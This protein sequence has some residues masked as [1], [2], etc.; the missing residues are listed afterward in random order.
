LPRRATAPP[1][2][3]PG[4]L[5]LWYEEPARSWPEALPIGNGRLGAMVFGGVT[6]ERLQLNEDTLYSDEPGQR[7]LPLEIT[8]HFDEVVRLL[9]RRYYREAEDLINRHWLGRVWPCYQPLADLEVDFGPPDRAQAYRRQLDL[10]TAICRV[11]YQ[12]RG[13]AFEREVF[14]SHPDQVIVM[15]VRAH[16]AQRLAFRASLT[17]V[18]PTARAAADGATGLILKGQAP[19][20]VIR[21]TLEWIEQMGDTWKYPELWDENG[22]R[23]PFARQVLYGAEIEGRG[24]FFEVRLRVLAQG[25]ETRAAA[26]GIRVTGANEAILL[27]SAATSYNGF[28][29]SPS[30]EGADPSERARQALEQACTKSYPELRE[31]HVRDYQALFHRVHLRLGPARQSNDVPTDE[32]LQRPEDDPNLAALYFQFGRYLLISSS[33][34]GTQPANLQG[35]WNPDVIPSW[36]CGYTT[37]INLQMNYWP[38]EVTNLSECAEPLFRLIRECALNGRK[39]AR[40]MYHRRGWVLHHNTTIWRDAQP[41]DN[42][43]FFSFYPMASGWLCQHLWDHYLFT[44][45]RKFLAEV[46]WPLMKE[47]AEFYLDWLIEDDEGYLVTP[48]GCSPENRFVYV[49]PDG[50]KKV[51]GICMGPTMDM[52]IIRELFHNSIEA[53]R[54]LDLDEDLRRRLED[55]LKRLRPYKVGRFGQL[56]EWYEDFE[57][58]EPGHRH[59]S[60]LY[61]LMP[62]RHITPR[63]TPELAQAARRSLERRLL[64]D[65]GVGG[66]SLAWHMNLWAR[67][68]EGD[69]AYEALLK[70]IRRE[71]HPSLLNKGGLRFQ[72]DGN[73]GGCAGIAE[74]LLQS[75]RDELHLLPA[76]PRAWAEGEVRG[77][78]ARGG[79]EVNLAWE[80]GQLQW[81]T[82]RSLAGEAC[83]VRYGQKTREFNTRPGGVYKLNADLELVP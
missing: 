14:A 61:G 12:R 47:A 67:L 5:T 56:Q 22:H 71:T 35:I 45:D 63:E 58:Y 42:Q 27:V 82:I 2:T 9:K 69:L 54:V 38:A 46:A 29:K 65:R 21:R 6:I 77:L 24:M 80:H 51:A 44:R 53:S 81:A 37:N 64:Y 78:R 33:R 83:R 55:H 50:T 62:G 73:L 57:E 75:H 43:A 39:V 17:S 60:H 13:T 8:E 68:E 3:E 76:L 26:D 41:V 40:Q 49:A 15:R 70:L 66:W 31:A 18:H 34:P 32:R 30:R 4:L 25:G 79:F 10:E 11:E 74:M 72:I 16:P 48:A 28:D 7:D 59:L 36:A 19:G 20:L 23:R 52:A 1:N